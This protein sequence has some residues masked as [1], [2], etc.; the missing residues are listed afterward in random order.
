MG[1]LI[2]PGREEFAF[3]TAQRLY[4]AAS[5]VGVLIK[6]LR[7]VYVSHMVN[8]AISKEDVLIKPLREEFAKRMAP[9]RHVNDAISK[10]DVTNMR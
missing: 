10:E 6:L 4:D 2:K 7:V 5:R 8:D 1:V 3:R 9:R